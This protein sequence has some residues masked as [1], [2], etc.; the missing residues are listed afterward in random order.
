MKWK[1]FLA[2]VFFAA[3]VLISNGVPAFPVIAGSCAVALWNL[4]RVRRQPD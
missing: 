1:Y 3:V 4:Y 2:A